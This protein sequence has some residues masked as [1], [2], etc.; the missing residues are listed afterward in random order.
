MVR[1]TKKSIETKKMTPNRLNK[2]MS[3]TING[4]AFRVGDTFNYLYIRKPGTTWV[5]MFRN[6]TIVAIE[7]VDGEK[8][9]VQVK[10][11]SDWLPAEARCELNHM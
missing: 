7:P 8:N 3:I 5:K 11:T 1:I 2:D 9:I 10:G 6:A 4:E